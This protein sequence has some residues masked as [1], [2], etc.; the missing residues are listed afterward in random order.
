VRLIFCLFIL[1]SGQY[2]LAQQ[3]LNSFSPPH[4]FNEAIIHFESERFAPAQALF[5]EIVGSGPNEWAL[6]SSYYEAICAIRL[7]QKEGERKLNAFVSAYPYHPKSAIAYYELGNY[8]FAK[9]DYFKAIDFFGRVKSENLS[10]KQKN[11]VN[12]KK[13]YSYLSEKDFDQALT[14]FNLT[15]SKQSEWSSASYYY[16]GFI[17]LEQQNYKASIN[18]LQ[19]VLGNENYRT[20]SIPLLLKAYYFDQDYSAILELVE[21]EDIN[22]A[23]EAFYIAEAYFL[24]KNY[25]ESAFYY[26]KS[27][28]D[29]ASPVRRPSFN[30]RAAVSH[31]EIGNK[32]KAT[33]YFEKVALTDD[34]LSH[35]ASF[36]LGK[37]YLQDGNFAFAKN[38]FYKCSQQDF[39]E[40][41]QFEALFLV[42][43]IDV[44]LQD[45][46]GAITTLNKYQ[47]INPNGEFR[48]EVN[49]L[50]SESYLR[51]NNYDQAIAYIESLPQRSAKVNEI[52]QRVTF[53]K[54]IQLFNDGSFRQAVNR[55]QQS[56]SVGIDYAMKG[57]A[58]FW[59]GEAFSI[60]KK[61]AEAEEAYLKALPNR[62]MS[63]EFRTKTHYGLGY[64][65]YN[66]Q[67]YDKALVHFKAYYETALK[68]PL[69]WNYQDAQIRL[70]DVYY[71]NKIYGSAYDLYIRALNEQHPESDYASYQAGIVEG[72]R[73]NQ[74]NAIKYFDLVIQDFSSSNLLGKALFQK[75]QLYFESGQYPEAISSYSEVVNTSNDQNLLGYA[76]L[77]RGLSR[78]N[79]KQLEEAVADYELILN[80]FP[81]HEVANSALLGL[82]EILQELGRGEELNAY[83]SLY[84]KANPGDSS[85]AGIEYGNA[86]GFYF[87]QEYTK[88][89]AAL[90]TFLQDYPDNNNVFEGRFYLAESYLRMD[91][92]DSA[93]KYYAQVV[94][95]NRTGRITRSLLRMGQIKENSDD[96]EGSILYYRKLAET[97]NNKRELY[98]AYSG[99]MR[100][101][102]DQ[103]KFDS[104]RYFANAVLTK[105]NVNVNAENEST[106]YLGKINFEQGNYDE[107]LDAFIEILNS[108]KDESGAEAQYLIARIYTNRGEY[109]QSIEALFDLNSNFSNYE[110]WLGRSFLL[111]ADNFMALDE[112]FQ[113]QETL[114][115]LIENSPL[116]AIVEEAEL[117]LKNLKKMEQQALLSDTLEQV[118]DVSDTLKSGS[119]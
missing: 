14:Y 80:Q 43:K 35:Y 114:I 52:Y 60:G 57:E 3:S 88:A 108:A 63:G 72:L 10:S 18:D 21:R 26:D 1:L 111:I 8:Y 79:L 113:A 19:N 28:K 5:L 50:L 102:F 46:A 104:T 11:E 23:N 99:L 36:E 32:N 98:F 81:N 112:F 119:Q 67:E 89:I 2:T 118:D 31:R 107:A 77:R 101:Y 15:K 40:D 4:E 75:A 87:N 93:F 27:L 30:Y 62:S 22:G 56:V 116:K 85:V 74:S 12:Y 105:A 20:P 110:L 51:T 48:S 55:L 58:L 33:T 17:N 6:Q 24:Q 96:L 64:L 66:T 91:N 54:G 7:D 49:D 76:V 41:L 86:K 103:Q 61:Y 84:R 109:K 106:L 45:Y 37:L 13:G 100:I 65:Y 42:G 9:G 59:M 83:L 29:K 38:A 82:Q 92:Q 53:L 47:E 16:A 68:E 94:E 95:D 78:S 97:T 73:G 90:S 69:K 34:T 44:Q 115:S 117:K 39:N 71:A 25:E 70:A